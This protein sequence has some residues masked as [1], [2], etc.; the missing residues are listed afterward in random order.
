VVG[1]K[2][3]GLK[4]VPDLIAGTGKSEEDRKRLKEALKV[5]WKAL[6]DEFFESLV[7][8]ILDRIQAFIDVNG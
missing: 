6:P 5:A 4:D 2:K 8:S 1:T 7:A 3:D